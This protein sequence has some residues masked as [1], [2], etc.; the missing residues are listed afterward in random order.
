VVGRR[1]GKEEEKP[2]SLEGVV[3]PGRYVDYHNKGRLNVISY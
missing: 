2:D 1:K 3:G